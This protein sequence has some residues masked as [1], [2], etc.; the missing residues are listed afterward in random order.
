MK[1]IMYGAIALLTAGILLSGISSCKKSDDN[2][3]TCQAGDGGITQVVV[4]AT[5]G[6]DT[7]LNTA[8]NDT[9]Y[10]KYGATSSPGTDPALYD[11]AYAG[12][13]GENHIHLT[14]LNCGSYYIYR[15][16]HDTA[17]GL[18]YSG[19]TALSFTQTSGEVDTV[20]ALQHD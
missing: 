2:G 15:V 16:S 19:G 7:V 1:K 17:T 11:K 13:A 6:G 9:A 18:R 4:F 5:I 20:I 3:A 14:R 12:E 10:V 8:G